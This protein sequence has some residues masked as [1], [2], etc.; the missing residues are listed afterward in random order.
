MIVQYFYIYSAV[1]FIQPDFLC[2]IFDFFFCGCVGMDL[3]DSDKNFLETAVSPPVV[4]NAFF[5]PDGET[6]TSLTDTIMSYLCNGI[7]QTSH[8][9]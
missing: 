4:A 2:N 9:S 3:S 1:F 7:F 8:I 5:L 6:L